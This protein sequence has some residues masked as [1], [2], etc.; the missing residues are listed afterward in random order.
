M[1]IGFEFGLNLGSVRPQNA[2]R[3]SI[4]AGPSCRAT[5]QEIS[6]QSL[7][8]EFSKGLYKG[9]SQGG[10]QWG[11]CKGTSKYCEAMCMKIAQ[12]ILARVGMRLSSQW[13]G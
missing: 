5:L 6:E 11:L 13:L 9:A 4:Q 3:E 10:L 1:Y 7:Q 2:C 8:G 12:G